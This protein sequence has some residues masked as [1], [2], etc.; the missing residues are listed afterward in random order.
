MPQLR[1]SLT[2][3]WKWETGIV[4]GAHYIAEERS[5]RGGGFLTR[6]FVHLVVN[7]TEGEKHPYCDG[8]DIGCS[9]DVVM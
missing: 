5:T 4:I 8:I 3:T 9:G 7:H 1:V 6:E 2:C